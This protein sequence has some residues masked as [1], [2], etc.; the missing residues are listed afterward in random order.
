MKTRYFALILIVITLVVIG[1]DLAKPQK[2]FRLAVSEGDYFYNRMAYHLEPFLEKYG[3]EIEIAKATTSIDANRMVS[4]GE[5]DLAFINNHSYSISQTEEVQVGRLRTITPLATRI[6]LAFSKNPL[7]DTATAKELFENKR[8]G[9]E[10]LNGEAHANMERLFNRT[11][12]NGVKI[13]QFEDNADVIVFW[14]TLYG[15]RAVKVINE[16]WHPFTFQQNWIEFLTINDNALRPFTLPKVPGDDRFI[17]INTIATEAILVGNSDLGENAIYE[18]AQ[19]IFEH[20]LD[21]MKSDLMYRTIDESFDQ[22]ALL[23]PLHGGTVS[24]LSRNQPTFF[25]RYSDVIALVLS[26]IAV[27]YGA[28]QAIRN[29]L[30]RRKKEQVDKYFLDFLEIRSDKSKPLDQ[31]VKN[32]DGLFQRA[33]E[34]MTNEKLEKSDFHI[35]SRL[36][37]Q[38]LTMLKFND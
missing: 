23:F 19:V 21:L 26:I 28:I 7:S 17:R 33:V 32:L 6:F 22:K 10:L 13:V 29:S 37:Q 38:E 18:L 9:I 34:Q 1:C 3:Y 4:I 24:F 5:A 31:K 8:V 30:A 2:R 25:E 15:E 36:I 27:L 20:R 16:G 12:I 11:K 35:I 14:G